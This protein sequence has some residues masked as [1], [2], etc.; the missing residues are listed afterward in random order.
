MNFE[1]GDLVK[2]KSGGPLM[3]VEEVG[4]IQGAEVVSCVW[5]EK[6]GNRQLRQ[7]ADF[8]PATLEKSSHPQG[9]IKIFRG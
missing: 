5:F 4:P 1:I 2:L 9:G 6:V 8:K 3:T 7:Q